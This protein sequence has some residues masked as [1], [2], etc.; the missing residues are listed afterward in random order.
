MKCSRKNVLAAA[1]LLLSTLLAGPAAAQISDAC[2]YRT[3]CDDPRG[4][5]CI[6]GN[7]VDDGKLRVTLSWT[8]KADLD[9]FLRL[10][11]GTL[12]AP[13]LGGSIQAEGGELRRDECYREADCEDSSGHAN[14]EHISWNGI[15]AV[16]KGQY[17]VWTTNFDGREA[18]DYVIEIKL[19]NQER[20]TF[21]GSVGAVEGEESTHEV[22]EVDEESIVCDVDTDGDGL[23]DR[24]EESGIDIDEDGTI[25]LD[26]PGLGADPQRKDLFVE[27]DR[28]K[29]VN[30]F[31]L[32]PVVSAFAN[33]PVS[34]PDGSTGIT[35][36]VLIDEEIDDVGGTA[37]GATD[38]LFL[39]DLSTLKF[40]SATTN[41]DS[42]SCSGGWFGTAADR[43]SANC[44]AII[45]ARRQVYRYSV[46]VEEYD[47]GGGPAGGGIAELPGND[48]IVAAASYNQK[49]QSAV[50]MHELGHTL[51]LRHGG[52]NH[53][54]CK[55]NYLSIMNY[56][57]AYDVYAP[58][59]P[60]DFSRHNTLTLDETVLDENAGVGGPASW[61]Q[62]VYYQ[63]MSVIATPDN[64]SKPIDWDL[65][66]AFAAGVVADIT[67]T[68]S[69]CQSISGSSV[70]VPQNDWLN[71]VYDFRSTSGYNN[72]FPSDY[73]PA[74]GEGVDREIDRD[75]FDEQAKQLD[76]DEDGVSNY[77]DNCPAHANPDQENA[78]DD[79]LGDACDGC[80]EISAPG[81]INGCP[82]GV[83]PT[84]EV[85][86]STIGT[87]G[88]ADEPGGD[89]SDP[90]ADGDGNPDTDDEGGV[91]AGDQLQPKQGCSTTGGTADLS[92]LGLFAIVLGFARRRRRASH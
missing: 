53:D 45:K 35:L 30:A 25:D 74:P 83:E 4:M 44:D 87:D 19:P 31:G 11:S 60:L 38:V 33:A 26:L 42:T 81:Y 40:N 55:P 52:G 71:L 82:D 14:I 64:A 47:D 39:S 34:N 43:A 79:D 57:Y 48:M 18:A 70:L 59:R 29:G 54:N 12:I 16:P 77:D 23:C 61:L 86:P 73:L 56:N 89:N 75:E 9:I 65:D 58:A 76:G 24:W 68:D 78:D 41:D 7:C 13:T 50:F 10:P 8:T 15:A 85:P 22:F 1:C 63:G 28:F 37:V 32:G 21:A 49:D 72:D 67:G 92:W 90:D 51:G 36:H 84:V 62:V 66:M 69:S 3:D 46:Y 88:P 6:A 80:P 20:L 17:E 91:E 2:N 27:V 5:T